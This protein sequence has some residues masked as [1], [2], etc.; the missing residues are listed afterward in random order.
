MD[1]DAIERAKQERI[2][3]EVKALRRARCIWQQCQPIAGTTGENYLRD[4]AITCDFPDSLRWLPH[5]YHLPSGRYCSAMVA[6]VQSAA[7]EPMGIHRTFFTK[8]GE[9]LPSRAKIML[10]PCRGGAVR[11]AEIYGPLV[12]A[13]GIETG[14]SL[15]SGLLRAPARIWAA[16]STSGM[17]GL[18]L[19]ADP[20]KLI[21]AA[22]GD[23][24]GR[25]AAHSLAERASALGWQVSLLPVPDETDWNDVLMKG[26]A[27]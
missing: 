25:K 3:A 26:D 23:E 5:T 18:G 27:Q 14:L 7:G 16:L 10:G 15:A 8:K 22:D 6:Q 11:L 1:I 13:E 19:T 17:A 2:D 12:V 20:G 24:A 9:R 4:R 21:I